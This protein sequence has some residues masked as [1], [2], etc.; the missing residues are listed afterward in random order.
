[1]YFIKKQSRI[2]N[3]P[4]TGISCN[5]A[6]IEKGLYCENLDDAVNDAKELSCVNGV[7]WGIV[8]IKY[9]TVLTIL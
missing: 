8:E 3:I 5:D 4:Y 1:M 9:E 6:G 2:E 7:G